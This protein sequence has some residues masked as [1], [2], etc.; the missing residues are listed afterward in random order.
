[1]KGISGNDKVMRYYEQNKKSVQKMMKWDIFNLQYRFPAFLLK[2]PYE[3]LNRINRNK[4][5]NAN[6]QLV[7]DIL[8]NDYEISNDP[9]TSLDLFC[10]MQK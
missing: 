9:D 5:H 3:L 7:S 6:D 8:H 10:V 2:L 1:M 4:L